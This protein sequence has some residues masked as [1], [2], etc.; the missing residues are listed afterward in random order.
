VAA[1]YPAGLQDGWIVQGTGETA[2]YLLRNGAKW[3][4]PDSKTL[5]NYRDVL[6]PDPKPGN[7]R[8]G[9]V[10]ASTVDQIPFAGV[11]PSTAFFTPAQVAGLNTAYS[12][13]GQAWANLNYA[14]GKDATALRQTAKAPQRV[15]QYA[16]NVNALIQTAQAAIGNTAYTPAQW[17]Q[18][19]QAALSSSQSILAVGA[20]DEKGADNVTAGQVVSL[21]GEAIATAVS[22]VASVVGGAGVAPA[23]AS[24]IALA[25]TAA[26]LA[27]HQ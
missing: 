15:A 21:C 5:T 26:A 12:T 24:G 23:V 10:P 13:L 9:T 2:I 14:L 20:A 11:L 6:G 27:G 4:F 22:V 17:N 19:A 25:S 1:T 7:Q 16:P 18:L 8:I 3:Q